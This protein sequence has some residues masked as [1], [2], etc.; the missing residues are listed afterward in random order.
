[1]RPRPRP[2]YVKQLISNVP[3]S[4]RCHFDRD[5]SAGSGRR[6]SCRQCEVPMNWRPPT[7]PTHHSYVVRTLA[8]GKRTI[9]GPAPI[10]ERPQQSRSVVDA[11]DGA[12]NIRQ[13]LAVWWMCERRETTVP[14]ESALIDDP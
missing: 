5:R 1:M 7:A 6:L 10:A 11:P 14:S 4:L 13:G 12:R 3:T 9:G 2:Q 8:A